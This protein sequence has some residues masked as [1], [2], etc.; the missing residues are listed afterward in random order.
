MSDTIPNVIQEA[1]YFREAVDRGFNKNLLIFIIKFRHFDDS[2]DHLKYLESVF[3]EGYCL[4]FANMLKYADSNPNGEVVWVRNHEHFCYKDANG[5]IYDIH[6][7]RAIYDPKYPY[8]Y[9]PSS[10]LG[11]LIAD[12]K[13]T[14]ESFTFTNTSDLTKRFEQWTSENFPQFPLAYII[15]SIYQT[16][17]DEYIVHDNNGTKELYLVEDAVLNYWSNHANECYDILAK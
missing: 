7:P 8:E 5:F 4:Y 3:T 16:L 13:W 15:A 6:G 17:S 11:N 10:I 12:F 14:D 1:K 2:L 9:V